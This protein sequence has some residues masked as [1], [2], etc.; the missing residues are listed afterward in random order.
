MNVIGL[1]SDDHETFLSALLADSLAFDA[2][3]AQVTLPLEGTK[4]AFMCWPLQYGCS[5][6][7]QCILS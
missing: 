6:S 7:L 2:G 1:L 5:G 3:E 4:R